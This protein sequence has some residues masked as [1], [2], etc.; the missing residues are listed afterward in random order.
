M[1]V[2]FIHGGFTQNKLSSANWQV[3]PT[4]LLLMQIAKIEK[5]KKNC[6]L[7]NRKESKNKMN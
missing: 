6:R 1:I 3:H 5:K 4:M 7:P 2:R